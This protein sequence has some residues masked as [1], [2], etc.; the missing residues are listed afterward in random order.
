MRAESRR[1]FRF[2]RRKYCCAGGTQRRRRPVGDLDAH[3]LPRTSRQTS[4]R[5][6]ATPARRAGARRLRRRRRQPLVHRERQRRRPPRSPGRASAT[7]PAT[8]TNGIAFSR[9]MSRVSARRSGRNC[10]RSSRCSLRVGELQRDQRR[11]HVAGELQ[12]LARDQQHLLDLGQR[13]LV[14][15]RR[16]IA[17]ERLQRRLL[18]LRFGE[19]RLE[20][21]DLRLRVAQLGRE[22]RLRLAGRLRRRLD[23]G[24][25]LRDL[26]AQRLLARRGRRATPASAATTASAAT[27]GDHRARDRVR[28][29]RRDGRARLRRTRP[30]TPRGGVPA[31]PAASSPAAGTGRSAVSD[32]DIGPDIDGSILAGG[33]ARTAV[34]TAIGRQPRARLQSRS[35]TRRSRVAPRRPPALRPARSRFI[36]PSDPRPAAVLDPSRPRSSLAIVV[37]LVVGSCVGRRVADRLGAPRPRRS[38]SPPAPAVPGAGGRSATAPAPAAPPAIGPAATAAAPPPP[39]RRRRRSPSARGSSGRSRRRPRRCAARSLR[40]TP[41][42]RSSRELADERRR[43]FDELAARARRDRAL[44]A[45]RRRPREQRAAAA[46]RGPGAPDDL[47]LI[48]GVGPVLERMLHQLGVDDLPPDR[49]LDRARHRRV[50]RAAARV[51]GP[52]PARRL[53]DAGA[54]AAPEQVRRDAPMR[55]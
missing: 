50:R 42:S 51:S 14:A 55:R 18:R 46:A 29:R 32:M 7:I 25:P 43:L 45:A 17:V 11:R 38:R 6:G 40:A 47:K 35:T 10:G 3:E 53:G 48:V 30:A 8:S 33:S 44:P 1:S 28:A 39:H 13:D 24:E 37:A 31:V 23:V 34:R 22:L 27:R 26:G 9:S 5:S 20:Q 19:P 49:A 15:R 16:E 4:R 36:A 54:R 21:R 52:H 41:R 2:S 12:L